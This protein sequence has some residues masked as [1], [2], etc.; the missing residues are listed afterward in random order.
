MITTVRIAG[1]L[2]YLEIPRGLMV[3]SA[4]L[5][6]IPEDKLV[7]LTTGSQ[8]EPLSALS[9]MASDRHK[10]LQIESGDTVIFSSRF[11]P[12]NEKAIYTII[13]ALYRRGARVIYEPLKE[14]HVSGHASREE[15]K[16]MIHLTSPDYFIPIHGEF[17]HLIQH[18]ELAKEVGVMSERSVVAE[19]GDVYVL[20]AGGLELE[21]QIEV[22]RVY[23][24]GKGVG[25]VGEHVLRDRQHLS[26]DGLVVA[27][28]VLNKMTGELIS[29]PELFSRGFTLD[30]DRAQ[31]MLVAREIVS[32]AVMDTRNCPNGEPPGDLQAGI[33]GA[34]KSHFWRT[35]R[36]RPMIM[37]LVVEL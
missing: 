32:N 3:E 13:N 34:L 1:E 37:P 24:D 18:A 25:D 4:G 29:E 33:R 23:V 30:A 20:T 36:R 9:L 5:A 7:V 21:G 14:V 15:L 10:W 35:I 11:I 22:G 12:G 19:N 17:R 27:L 2:G 31:M 26:G 28:V 8:G 6:K 16:L